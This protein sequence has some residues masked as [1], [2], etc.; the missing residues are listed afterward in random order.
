MQS[1]KVDFKVENLGLFLF[2]LDFVFILAV[3]RAALMRRRR[4]QPRIQNNKVRLTCLS[5]FSA[6][7]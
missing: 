5:F 3:G 4:Q 2:I 7:N 1:L 6:G